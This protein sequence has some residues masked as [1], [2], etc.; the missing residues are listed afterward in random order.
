MHELSLVLKVIGDIK[1]FT[2]TSVSNIRKDK[3]EALVPSSQA[4]NRL[5]H[6]DL[7]PK[8]LSRT[9]YFRVLYLY[10]TNGKSSVDTDLECRNK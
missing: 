10:F 5:Y 8:K 1:N 3:N 4:I 9:H 2:L 7:I 6:E